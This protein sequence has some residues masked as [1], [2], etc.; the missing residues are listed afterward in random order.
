VTEVEAGSAAAQRGLRPGD[1]IVAVN[2]RPVRDLQQL[3]EIADTNRIL[4]LLV[5]RGNRSLMLQIR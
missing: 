1:L 5:E 3:Q 4:F 2:R